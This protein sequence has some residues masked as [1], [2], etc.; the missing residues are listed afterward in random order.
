MSFVE[1][2]LNGGGT[3]PAGIPAWIWEGG[4]AFNYLYNVTDADTEHNIINDE[5]DATGVIGVIG[6]LAQLGL[7]PFRNKT[8]FVSD[9]DRRVTNLMSDFDDQITSFLL[10]SGMLTEADEEIGGYS[11]AYNN[12][13]IDTYENAGDSS[14]DA[15]INRSITDSDFGLSKILTGV[16]AGVVGTGA[17]ALAREASAT[18]K[19]REFIGDINEVSQDALDALLSNTVVTK[20]PSVLTRTLFADALT[21]ADNYLDAIDNVKD[22]TIA[23]SDMQNLFNGGSGTLLTAESVWAGTLR[24]ILSAQITQAITDASAVIASASFDNLVTTYETKM[25][26]M[27]YRNVNRLN[28][29]LVD[30]N[31]QQSSAFLFANASLLK[32]FE[33]DVAEYRAKM[34]QD[35]FDRCVTTFVTTFAESLNQSLRAQVETLGMYLQGF[36]KEYETKVVSYMQFVEMLHKL[37]SNS[38]ETYLKGSL[39]I[40]DNGVNLFG[41]LSSTALNSIS[42]NVGQMMRNTLENTLNNRGS[43]VDMIKSLMAVKAS[44]EGLYLNS[45]QAATQLQLTKAVNA[46]QLFLTEAEADYKAKYA[47]LD[48]D[49]KLKALERAGNFLNMSSGVS[50][51]HTTTPNV[52]QNLMYMMQGIGALTGAAGKIATQI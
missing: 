34:E 46:S 48:S 33:I 11:T 32:G 16:N 50:V 12:L 41:N 23:I 39:N 26:S 35:L 52:A 37:L 1:Q 22:V 18:V 20:K 5:I 15:Q 36:V 45:L 9:A 31:A 25:S 10:N 19:I 6:D 27:Y 43:R 47:A 30:I 13:L 7:N 8:T 4:N 28:G 51:G 40:A 3:T 2:K 49:W 14:L 29:G 24:G 17:T 44:K 38:M 42:S 21:N